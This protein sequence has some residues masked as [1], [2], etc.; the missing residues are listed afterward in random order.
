MSPLRWH[1]ARWRY[2]RY[3]MEL[4]GG[5]ED[6]VWHLAYGSNMNETVFCWRR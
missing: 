1:M 5:P 6:H 2:R 3:G 4:K